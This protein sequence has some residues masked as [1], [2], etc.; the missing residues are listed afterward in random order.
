MKLIKLVYS[1]KKIFGTCLL[2]LNLL[3]FLLY[4]TV[5]TS[6]II[7]LTDNYDNRGNYDKSKNDTNQLDVYDNQS[8]KTSNMI[9]L[10]Y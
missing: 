10:I 3:S 1:K 7:I 8:I 5:K 4:L 6:N 9:H 2:M